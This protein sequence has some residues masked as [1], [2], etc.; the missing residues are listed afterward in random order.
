MLYLIVF[1]VAAVI[2]LLLWRAMS[3][4][5]ADVPRGTGTAGPA[6]PPRRTRATGPDD[7]PDFLRS[8]DET[9]RRGDD[10]PPPAKD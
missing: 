4:D 1:A 10:P 9:M 6:A 7:D 5:R 2:A 8:L 3:G